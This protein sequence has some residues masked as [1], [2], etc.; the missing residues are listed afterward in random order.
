MLFHTPDTFVVG[1]ACGTLGCTRNSF[2][3][4][5]S[6]LMM[7]YP[8]KSN[9]VVANVYS[10]KLLLITLITR[11][12][13]VSG[14]KISSRP[15]FLSSSVSGNFLSVRNFHQR[16]PLGIFSSSELCR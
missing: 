11:H 7:P 16:C 6:L 8:F 15:K 1:G 13:A 12:L 10:S 9:Q 14:G 4:P 5:T 3:H 2:G